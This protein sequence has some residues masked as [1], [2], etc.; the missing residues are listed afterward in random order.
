MIDIAQQ[1]GFDWFP[2]ARDCVSRYLNMPVQAAPGFDL[3]PT[4]FNPLRNQYDASA[5]INVLVKERPASASYA[6]Y[7]VDVDL[8]AMRMNFIFGLADTLNRAAVV[9]AFRF[10]SEKKEEHFCTEIVHEI[11]HLLGLPHCRTGSCAMHFS[12][13]VEDTRNKSASLC[14]TCR[15]KLEAL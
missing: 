2:S 8:Y 10:R 14:P 4:A 5:L 9:S 7:L 1:K 13:T 15:R 6:L 3:P 11:G 12:H